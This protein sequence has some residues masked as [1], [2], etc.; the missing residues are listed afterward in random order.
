M[1]DMEI[2]LE[3]GVVFPGCGGGSSAVGEVVF[4]TASSG[5]PQALSDP[6]F[7]GQI[8][9]FAFP[10]IGNYGVDEHLLE[11]E[12]PWVRAV[13]V[14][15][16]ENGCT[17][18][19]E[20]TEWLSGFDIPIVRKVDT[21]SLIRHIRT[22]GALQGSVGPAGRGYREERDRRH[23]VEEVSARSCEVMEGSGPTVVVV[24]YG[25]KRGIQRE[26]C[27]RSCRVVKVPHN[28]SAEEILSWKPDGVLLGNG[29]GDPS[30][31]KAEIE[32][33]RSI[34]G[35]VPVGGICL[36]L[37]VIALASGASTF[38]LPF[39]HRGANHAVLEIDSGRALVTSQNHGYAVDESSLD[40]TGMEISH[41]N[42]GDGS[43]EGLRDRKRSVIA[44]Q[45]HPEGSP[46][47]K[48]GE[49]FFNDFLSMC[50][51]EAGL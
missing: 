1:L 41:K 23:P 27:S 48:D 35:K 32:T 7:A 47:P 4:T 11:S 25:L 28:S 20:I 43:I 33:A 40:G 29:P 10:M 46:G 42:L 37:Q 3:D 50:G 8:L 14:D 24:D 49:D 6:S 2:V 31:L 17:L 51:L 45:Y 34:I 36:G 21:R 26:L 19:P 12:R 5:Y 38:K 13:V 9:V 22:K 44:V 30:L 18:G 15:S 16:I 39:G